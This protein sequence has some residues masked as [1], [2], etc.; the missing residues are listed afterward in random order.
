MESNLILIE[1][2]VEVCIMLVVIVLKDVRLQ[3]NV[4]GKVKEKNVKKELKKSKV[5]EVLGQNYLRFG[6]SS[7]GRYLAF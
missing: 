2:Y 3:V 6:I 5:E 7:S 1:H 4:N